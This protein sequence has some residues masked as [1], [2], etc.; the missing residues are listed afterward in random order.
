MGVYSF[1]SS[2]WLRTAGFGNVFMPFIKR[3]NISGG[4]LLERAGHRPI[5]ASEFHMLQQ[6][7]G[8]TCF[9]CTSF[10]ELKMRRFYQILHNLTVMMD[11][12]DSLNCGNYL[13][14]PLLVQAVETSPYAQTSRKAR[15]GLLA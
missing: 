6:E 5:T 7:T 3:R 10:D 14:N 8:H 12:V 15:M 11:T 1:D 4:R 2:C 9:F 13:N